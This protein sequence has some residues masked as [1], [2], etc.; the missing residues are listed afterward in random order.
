MDSYNACVN[1]CSRSFSKPC[2]FNACKNICS[3]QTQYAMAT[4]QLS[5]S[6]YG[7]VSV[8]NFF[9]P[10]AQDYLVINRAAQS[11]QNQ[12]FNWLRSFL[13][14]PPS[15]VRNMVANMYAA[16]APSSYSATPSSAGTTVQTNIPAWM[17][18][19][20]NHH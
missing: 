20:Y 19:A 12:S 5:G 2:E 1:R 3:A 15:S 17:S 9:W 7:G 6:A 4:A 18:A 11:A 13:D 14:V 8:N 16:R 10:D